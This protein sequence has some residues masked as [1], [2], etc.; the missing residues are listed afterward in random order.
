MNRRIGRSLL[1]A[2]RFPLVLPPSVAALVF[3][4]TLHLLLFV[5]SL[6]GLPAQDYEPYWTSPL[7]AGLSLVGMMR[8]GGLLLAGYVLFDFLLFFRNAPARKLVRYLSIAGICVF[9][10]G[11]QLVLFSI[12]SVAER[13]SAARNVPVLRERLGDADPQVQEE[14]LQSLG[15]YGPR[16]LAAVPDLITFLGHERRSLRRVAA[17]ALGAVGPEAERAVPALTGILRQDPCEG[18]RA[19]A[20]YA[21][22]RIARRTS[23]PALTRA[24]S[25]AESNYV[26]ENAAWAIGTIGPEANAAVP[27]LT[28]A[29]EDDPRIRTAARWALDRISNPSR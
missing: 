4:V 6:V 1:Q 25:H 9:M 17:S 23:L 29:L 8:I 7:G 12:G 24:L 16:A 10:A 3:F 21:L 5:N 15:A 27:D 11:F 28:R 18:V 22:A 13:W 14:A 20:A 26:R 2:A 19:A